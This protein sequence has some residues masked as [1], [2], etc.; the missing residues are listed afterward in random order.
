MGCG[1]SAAPPPRADVKEEKPGPAAVP[2]PQPAEPPKAA[3]G[4][5]QE[6]AA[7]PV[8]EAQPPAEVKPEVAPEVAVAE[9]VPPRPCLHAYAFAGRAELARLIAAAG[10]LDIDEKTELEE[11]VHF[12]SPGSL[13]C[14]EHGSLRIAQ[15]FAIESYIASIAPGF[16]DLT[17]LQRAT[18]AMYCKIKEDMIAV[19]IANVST[20]VAD[21]SQKAV[22][23][24]NVAQL[25]DKWFPVIE[26][27]LPSTG[28][29]NG[30]DFPTA[31]DL[32]VLNVARGFMPFGAAYMMG[33]YD[34]SA[35]FAKFAAHTE[36]VA[37]HPSVKAFL[38]RSNTMDADPMDLRAGTQS[39]PSQAAESQAKEEVAAA[40]LGEKEAA[41]PAA[42]QAKEGT[43]DAAAEG[44]AS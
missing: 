32:A 9:P 40:S 6:K 42:P 43:A 4:Y 38:E 35:K 26:G 1:A 34:A 37:A 12:G 39:R 3:T 13:P 31:A 33:S 22:V 41:G 8:A 10:G 20:L 15:S 7:K 44:K 17:A 18:D 25:G 29:V 19:C 23:A 14:L 11:T 16:K 36:R 21:G 30:L 24:E 28:F 2:K 27:M 5:P